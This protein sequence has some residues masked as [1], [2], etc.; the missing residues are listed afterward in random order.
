L[1]PYTPISPP[2][3]HNRRKPIARLYTTLLAILVALTLLPAANSP[4][5]A[6]PANNLQSAIRNPQSG[7]PYTGDPIAPRPAPGTPAPY[8][9]YY[10]ETGHYLSGEFRDFYNATPN[11]A[12]I[13]G[14][15]ISEEFP[16]QFMNGAIFRVQYFERARF[17]W[18]PELP[19]GKR[20]Q[21]GTLAPTVLQ[22][23]TFDQLPIVASTAT[24]AYFPETGHTL[25]N[26][27]LNYWKTNGGLGVFGYPISEEMGE[28]GTTVQ[29]FERARFEY[30][31]DLEG[32]A[33]AVQLSPVGYLALRAFGFNLPMGT[34]LSFNPPV[35]AEGHTAVL[36]VAA[37][38][39]VTVTGQ[40]EGRPLF[41]TQ[42]PDKGIAWT[43]IGAVPFADLG[44]HP[45][46]VDLQSGDGGKRTVARN[47]QVASYPFPSESL[48][49][50]P[51]T[52]QLLDPAFTQPESD[53]LDKIFS[54]RT[55]Q[56]YWDGPFRMPL[57]GPIRITSYFAT[58]RCYNCPDGS[59]PTSYHGGMDMA[60][61]EGTPVRAP[62]NGVV[63]FAGKLNVRGNAIIIDHG[64]GVYSLFAHNSRLIAT[65]GQSVK[66]GDTISL[67]G[68]TGL[69]NGP[70]LHWEL[71]VSGPAVEPRE[72]VKRALP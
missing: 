46:T 60:A 32:T 36:T 26:G 9:R 23:R 35:V 31:G 61:V 25:S 54:G 49:F 5:L 56:Q 45:V 63:V 48:Q 11:S 64:L 69:S 33:Y 70:H 58:R 1:R 57:D 18:H 67:S 7:Q 16:Q 72:W 10:T 27:F 39:G 15:P 50:D 12:Y 2:K 41:F 47:L 37:S 44:P 28:D 62:A 14:L 6:H 66:K 38:P 29:Y 55:P 13:F 65:V 34:M 8:T 43:L 51:E 20:V 53:L 59:T 71:H 68:N 40:Y 4:A 19:E 3:S 22:G 24:R 21:L 17:E 30:H 42:Q 52:A